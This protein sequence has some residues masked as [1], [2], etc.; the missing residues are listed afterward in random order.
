VAPALNLLTSAEAANLI[1]YVKS[2][3][4]L[5]LGPRSGMKD[6]DN[7][8][9]PQRQPGPLAELLGGRVEQFYA[10]T[11][12]VPTEGDLDTGD[13]TIWAELLSTNSAETHVLAR[14]GKSN[15]WLDGQPAILTR[16]VGK[17]SITYVG[18]CFDEDGMQALAHWM[19]QQF[20]LTTPLPNVPEGVEASQRYGKDHVVTLLVNFSGKEQ[21]IKL[22]QPM[23]DVLQG[24]ETAAVHL[25]IYGVAVLDRKK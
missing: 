1:A 8:L 7:A 22:P 11:K 16:K 5:V 19:Q 20:N 3:G 2:G 14:Y 9:Q 23:H 13:A 25:G 10:L 12:D 18:A 17:G 4:N 15:G 21:D 6:E 24:G